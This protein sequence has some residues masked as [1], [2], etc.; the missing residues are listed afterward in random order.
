[1]IASFQ[2][3]DFEYLD[4]EGLHTMRRFGDQFEC[5]ALSLDVTT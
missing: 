1:M 5:N 4:E 3:N 2:S